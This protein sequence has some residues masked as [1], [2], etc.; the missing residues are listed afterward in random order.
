VIDIG[1]QFMY[2]SRLPMKLNHVQARV[3]LSA[4]GNSFGM[5]KVSLASLFGGQSPSKVWITLN[6]D[7]FV[8]FPSKVIDNWQ[9]P[10][11]CI[12][13]PARSRRIGLSTGSSFIAEILYDDALPVDLQGKSLP[14][15][16]SGEFSRLA[17]LKGT[18]DTIFTCALATPRR[19][20]ARMPQELML[21]G[22]SMSG[23][24]WWC[25]VMRVEVVEV[26][27]VEEDELELE[28]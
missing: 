9:V 27:V 7:C 24:V 20:K 12:A 11:P 13:L 15:A 2:I 3:A 26:V 8:G 16:L 19:A 14:S 6:T 21:K 17:T 28:N 22:M 23:G 5:L 25:V 1:A 4:L 10:P 18:G